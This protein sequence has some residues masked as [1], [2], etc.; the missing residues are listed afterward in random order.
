VAT[1]PKY[2]LFHVSKGLAALITCVAQALNES[3]PTFQKRF[4]NKLE[5]A[6]DV[7]RHDT[8]GDVRQELELLSTVREEIGP[9]DETSRKIEGRVPIGPSLNPNYRDPRAQ[10]AT[11]KNADEERLRGIE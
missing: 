4:L 3:D 10:L 1:A 5:T 9:R 7:I 2:D 6:Y 8:E 11:S